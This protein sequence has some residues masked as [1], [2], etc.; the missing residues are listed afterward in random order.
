MIGDYR[1][2][3]GTSFRSWNQT[4]IHRRRRSSKCQL[5]RERLWRRFSGKLKRNYGGIFK[6]ES[7]YYGLLLRRPNTKTAGGHQGK[8][9]RKTA[10]WSAVAMAAIE[11][12]GYE[13]H[14]HSPYLPDLAPSDFY[15][16]PRLK[17]HPRGKKNLKTTA[18]DG[19]CWGIFSESRFLL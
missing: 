18:S 12:S 19:R 2:V 1:W 3:L 9:T 17:E 14:E 5:R 4:T 13:L 7:H 8:K 6:K 11:E 16:F 10:G 15:F